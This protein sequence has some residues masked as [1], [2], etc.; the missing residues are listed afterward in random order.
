M[1]ERDDVI[2]EQLGFQPEPAPE[3]PPETKRYEWVFGGYS[4]PLCATLGDIA[5]R[6]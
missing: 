5:R 3:R 2:L 4:V 6:V 1:R